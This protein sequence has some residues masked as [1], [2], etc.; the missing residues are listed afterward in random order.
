MTSS[1]R[2]QVEPWSQTRVVSGYGL[3]LVELREPGLEERQV[4]WIG[5][6]GSKRLAGVH[7]CVAAYSWIGLGQRHSRKEQRHQKY[8]NRSELY[9]FH[10]WSPSLSKH[11]IPSCWACSQTAIVLAIGECPVD[12]K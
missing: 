9:C 1:A 10:S 12:W 2:V 5:A 3:V 6:D 11:T 7:S 8:E 4:A